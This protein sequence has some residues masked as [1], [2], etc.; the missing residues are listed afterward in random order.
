[1]EVQ[2]AMTARLAME[3]RKTMPVSPG[4]A[5]FTGMT[6][7]KSSQSEDLSDVSQM[8]VLMNFRTRFWLWQHGSDSAE[9]EK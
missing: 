6:D 3:V 1:M 5:S 9:E 8:V 4:N 7:G 2:K